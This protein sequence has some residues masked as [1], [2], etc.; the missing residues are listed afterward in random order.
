MSV[1]RKLGAI[2]GVAVLLL[3]ACTSAQQPTSTPTSVPRP[4]ATSVAPGVMPTATP[5]T[6]PAGG[7]PTV[8]PTPAAKPTS[9]AAQ[10][11]PKRGG[12]LFMPMRDDPTS[13]DPHFTHVDATAETTSMVFAGLLKSNP[14]PDKVCQS[15]IAPMMATSWKWTTDTTL[16]FEIR[17][18]VKYQ[19]KA[20][21]NGRVMTPQDVVSSFQR[22]KEM[23]PRTKPFTDH[24]TSIQATGKNTVQFKTDIPFPA[25]VSDL[26]ALSR[27]AFVV[28]PEAAV[29]GKYE[30]PAKTH[31]GTGPFVFNRYVPAVRMDYQR[32]PDYFDQPK[33]YLDAV[34]YYVMP[35]MSTRL[36]A[37]RS[38]KINLVKDVDGGSILDVKRLSPNLTPYVCEGQS[39]EHIYMRT[40]LAPYNDLRVRQA[41][42]LAINRQG[43]I[44]AIFQGEGRITPV[45]PSVLPGAMTIQDFP[46]EIR[47][48]LEFR[49]DEARALLRE[50]APAGLKVQ[51]RGTPRYPSPYPELIQAVAAD[52]QKVGFQVEIDMQEYGAYT[53]TTLLGDFPQMALTHGL[54]TAEA[55]AKGLPGY[56]SKS[57]WGNNRSHVTDPELDSMIDRWLVTLDDQQRKALGWDIQKYVVQKAY[58]V[59][60]PVPNDSL[61]VRPEVKD[62]TWRSSERIV[63]PWLAQI[64]LDQ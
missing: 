49:P 38:G 5:A 50:A 32:N 54:T 53:R 34:V 3:A 15:V 51:L 43:I 64:W 14:T 16:E 17:E 44:D 1:T 27:G 20:P 39:P 23:L 8:Q 29:G 33:P 45:L 2:A 26:F 18:G 63:G 47:K 4:T 10:S 41:I 22:L 59:V 7:G 31:I 55:D 46:P 62:A 9:P 19:N 35:E 12:T 48:Y 61:F 57:G 24:I 6:Q 40:D 30:D 25:L 42:S 36:A 13:W 58:R 37:L 56:H 60:L 11:Q 52:L 28:A 21:V